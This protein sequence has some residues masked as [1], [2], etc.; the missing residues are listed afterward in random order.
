MLKECDNKINSLGLESIE[1]LGFSNSEELEQAL[2][3]LMAE[4]IEESSIAA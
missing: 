2:T 4:V 3:L 1:D